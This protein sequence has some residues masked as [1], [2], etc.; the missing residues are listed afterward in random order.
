[1]IT[2]SRIDETLKELFSNSGIPE[3]PSG[4]Y[5]P[6]RYM[7]SIGGKRIRPR[8]CLTA[9]SLYKD[10]FDEGILQPAAG[11]EFFHS[12][13]LIHDDI[14][15]DSSLRRGS[16]TVWKKW[17]DNTAIL[18]GDVMCIESYR[19]IAK[20]PDACLRRVLDLFTDTAAQVCDG[21]QYDMEFESLE[22][23]SM[24]HY[25]KMIGLKTAVLIACAAKMGAIIGGADEKDCHNIYE[26]AYALGL[27]FQITDD[28]L[29]A[30]GDAR[31]FGKPIGGD[32]LNN[33]KSWLINRCLQKADQASEVSRK[34][35]MTAKAALEKS[36][37][38]PSGS[39]EE[40]EAKIAAVKD[41]YTFLHVDED[42]K[43]E[44]LRLND[45]AMCYA[46]KLSVGKLRVEELHRFAEKL[47][48][49]AR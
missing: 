40:K 13:T 17:G 14:M 27:A 22:Q 37:R 16:Q 25:M 36:M 1:M 45:K 12:F 31:V 39:D 30:F 8:L 32:I 23:V 18:S 41:M 2:Q 15:D 10:E 33:K 11:L 19:R 6:L 34:L 42:A 47:I 49:R 21:Q 38:M 29:D 44:I 20:A 28:Y 24:D 43:Y 5:E 46:E 26:Y 3:E 35:G 7:L 48:G 4:L 9:Y